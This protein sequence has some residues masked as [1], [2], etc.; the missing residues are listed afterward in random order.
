MSINNIPELRDFM[1]Y[2]GHLAQKRDAIGKIPIEDL[3]DQR[4]MPNNKSLTSSGLT[5][6]YAALAVSIMG[7]IAMYNVLIGSYS[8]DEQDIKDTSVQRVPTIVAQ[9]ELVK[10][11]LINS[12]AAP[13]KNQ[14]KQN[15]MD[16]F[17][18]YA[19]Q[20]VYENEAMQ[21]SAISE[22]LTNDE[23][24]SIVSEAESKILRNV[25][26]W[27]YEFDAI[28]LAASRGNEFLEAYNSR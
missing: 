23:L 18:D 22:S 27:K 7:A 4:L 28:E 9:K 6:P 16:S 21:H 14:N 20:F 24:V 1:P 8:K 2:K 19:S 11:S 10:F 17:V 25:K 13:S 5:L 12:F 3:L 15:P 26:I